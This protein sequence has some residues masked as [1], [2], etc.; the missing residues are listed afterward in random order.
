VAAIML[1]QGRFAHACAG[2]FNIPAGHMFIY[3]KWE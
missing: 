3:V 1:K 2:Q